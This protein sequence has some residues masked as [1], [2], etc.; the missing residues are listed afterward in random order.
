MAYKNMK[1]AKLLAAI[2]ALFLQKGLDAVTISEVAFLASVPVGNV[3]YYFKTK[4]AM[5]QEALKIRLSRLQD[6][7]SSI[8]RRTRSPK[9]HMQDFITLFLGYP[10]EKVPD[11]RPFARDNDEGVQEVIEF[12]PSLGKFVT[13][14][15]L[16][17][18]KN[19]NKEIYEAFFPIVD[20]ILGWCSIKFI[21]LGKSIVDAEATAMK[22]LNALVGA[23]VFSLNTNVRPPAEDT[24]TQY[25]EFII[26]TFGLEEKDTSKV[27]YFT[28]YKKP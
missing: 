27:T 13:T 17:L 24:N 5:V 6:D 28:E 19:R 8:E 2:D 25:V 9:L 18:E 14:L 22:F 16:D 7:L 26:Q 4:T 3:Y 21:E 20:Y 11:G 10:K 1:R 12:R 15:L 23:C